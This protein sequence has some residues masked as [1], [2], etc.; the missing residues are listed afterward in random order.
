MTTH[1]RSAWPSGVRSAALRCSGVGGSGVAGNM[2]ILGRAHESGGGPTGCERDSSGA[3]RGASQPSRR[4]R[5]SRGRCAAAVARLLSDGVGRSV[6][7]AAL[8]SARGAVCPREGVEGAAGG[9]GQWRRACSPAFTSPHRPHLASTP[10]SLPPPPSSLR[11]SHGHARP[12]HLGSPPARHPLVPLRC[13]AVP[14]SPLPSS[15]D[16]SRPRLISTLAAPSRP[17]CIDSL[18]WSPLTARPLAAAQS[19]AAKRA[20][21]LSSCKQR[22][23]PTLT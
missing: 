2:G 16:R 22:C 8:Q 1:E 6:V 14:P 10:P 13:V 3:A 11:S 12:P 20:Y 9:M 19:A 15:C 4:V 5:L 18:G 21:P 23:E 17:L 7:E